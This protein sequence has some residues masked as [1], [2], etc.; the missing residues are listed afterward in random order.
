MTTGSPIRTT[1]GAMSQFPAAASNKLVLFTAGS[2]PNFSNFLNETWGYNG[3]TNTWTDQSPNLINTGSPSGRINS[4]MSYDGTNLVLFGGQS[5][6]AT[7]GILGDTWTYSPSGI[8][9]QIG[10]IGFSLVSPYGRYNCESAFV[11]GAGSAA[12]VLLFGGQNINFNTVDTWLWSGTLQTW[13]QQTV[14]NGTGPYSRIGHVMAGSNNSPGTVLMFGGESTK[15]QLNDTWQWTAASSWQ[16]QS[17]TVSPSVRS[18]ASMDYD[19]ANT[20]WVMHGGTNEY[21]YLNE[22]WIYKTGNWSQV[23]IPA[24]TGPL[25]RKNAQIAY[26]AGAGY[27][28]LFGGTVATTGYPD[29]TTWQLQ[30]GATP[31]WVQ[32]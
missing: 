14:A 32:V 12:G 27:I 28:T 7:A 2:F 15:Q 5:P 30:G 17:P 13:T 11:G 8:W 10:G 3:A 4:T 24:G 25:G 21:G 1:N 22:T 29:N 23:S 31:V 9:T 19:I 26:D 6:S 18:W 16:Q 20:R